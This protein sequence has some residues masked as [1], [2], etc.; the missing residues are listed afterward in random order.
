VRAA[1]QNGNP[2]SHPVVE[3]DQLVDKVVGRE[4]ADEGQQGSSVRAGIFL[5]GN[6]DS[7][8]MVATT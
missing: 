2:K 8:V 7:G 5:R 1:Y 6:D 4:A 3:V